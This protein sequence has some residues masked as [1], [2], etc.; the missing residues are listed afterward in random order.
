MQSLGII[1][2]RLGEALKQVQ[3]Q[4]VV[5]EALAPLLPEVLM[6]LKNIA[7]S[8][9]AESTRLRAIEMILSL[10]ARTVRLDIKQTAVQAKKAKAIAKREAAIAQRQAAKN[11]GIRNQLK[12]AAERK[13]FSRVLARAKK[14]QGEDS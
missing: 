7:V 2:A 12:V 3:D 1:S 6:S 4:K 10:F 11:E 8:S 13:K 14:E 9:Q 5:T